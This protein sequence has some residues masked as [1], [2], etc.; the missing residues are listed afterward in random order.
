MSVTK[1]HIDELLDGVRKEGRPRIEMAPLAKA[2]AAVPAPWVEILTHEE[3]AKAVWDVLWTPAA[4][5]L[6][7]T[8]KVFKKCLQGV[9][10]LT[11][12]KRPPSLLYVITEGGGADAYAYRGYAAGP[13]E[14]PDAKSLPAGFLKFYQEV[15][16][17]WGLLW[18]GSVGPLPV[19]DWAMLSEDENTP[20]GRFLSVF[21]DGGNASLGFDL[22][23]EPPLCYAVWADDEPE[24]VPDVWR[25]IDKWIAGQQDDLDPA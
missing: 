23:E 25:T 11:T 12:R 19:Q 3:P 6:P 17:G 4:K 14:H 22:D 1:A 21:D 13:V 24:V 10:L 15:H 20:A 5:D 16:N 8:L 2:P 7:R 18:D 9:G